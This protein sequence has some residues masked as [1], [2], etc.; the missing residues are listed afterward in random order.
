VESGRSRVVFLTGHRLIEGVR[1]DS[2]DAADRLMLLEETGPP[3]KLRLR[4]FAAH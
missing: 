2:L 3:G 1:I 4:T